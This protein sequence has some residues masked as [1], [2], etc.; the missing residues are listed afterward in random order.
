M[1][2]AVTLDTSV[3][4]IL[5]SRPEAMRDPFPVW[6]RLR[7]EQPVH[8]RPE[9]VLL[10]RYADVKALIRDDRRLSSNAFQ[11]G[12][13]AESVR[14]GLRGEQLEAFEDVAAFEALYLSRSD[15]PAHDRLR[16]IA[17]R[18]F[19]PR[20]IA[21]L[22]T[23]VQRYTDELLP[24]AGDEVADFMEFAYRLPMMVIADLLGVPQ[25]D[26]ELIHGW[27]G[28]LGRN[29]GGTDVPAL[30]EAHAAL[31][32]FRAYVRGLVAEHARTPG[33]TDLVEALVGAEQEENLT[34][35]ELTATF[36]V[37]LFAGHETT[38]NLIGGGLQ[39]LMRHRDQWEK[40]TADPSLVP[41]AVE[42]LLRWVTP[43][44][45]LNRVALEDMQW[46][47]V[48]IAAGTSVTGILAAANRDPDVFSDPE[49][50]DITR[51]DAKHHIGL[52]FGPHFCLGASLARLEGTVAIATLARRFPDVEL[53]A[54]PDEWRGNAMLRSLAGLPIRPGRARA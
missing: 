45:W 44:Q 14:A 53:A 29:R 43:V 10:S 4:D 3:A 41:A 17:H 11:I 21:E 42:E 2:T 24:E 12:S 35:D 8:V 40:L 13:R 16:R 7:E 23:A 27:S 1:S 15:P 9:I 22:G 52:G 33:R 46:H 37:L 18:A 31:V 30:M 5:A 50:L 34:T 28:K 36:V 19:T 47:G 54:D 32:Q 26:R 49:T 38:T 51:P 20:R 48:P 6:A 39:Q 25:A